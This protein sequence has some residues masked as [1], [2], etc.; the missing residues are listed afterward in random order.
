[1]NL[2]R[3][4][5]VTTAMAAVMAGHT[6]VLAQVSKP[7]KAKSKSAFSFQNVVDKAQALSLKPYVAPATAL[8]AG[9]SDLSYDAYRR[10]QFLHPKA[11]WATDDLGFRLEM[12]HRGNLFKERIDLYEVRDGKALPIDYVP[13]Q[14]LYDPPL[15]TPLPADTGFAG[16]RLIAQNGI[17]LDEIAAFLG[18][19]YFRSLGRGTQ[20]GLSARGLAIATGNPGGEEFPIFRAY[21]IERP[22][23]GDTAIRVHALLDSVS[24]AGAYSFKITPGDTTLF[25][26]EATL[27]PRVALPEIGIAPLTSMFLFGP[28]TP[29]RF[30]DYRPAVQDSNGFEMLTGTDEAIWRPLINPARLTE[31]AFSDTSPHGFG[32]I[33]RATSFNDYQDLEARY[34]RRPSA[35]ITPIG[36]WNEG[37]VHLFEFP[38]QTEDF[39]NIVAMWRPNTSLAPHQSHTY[40]YNIAWGPHKAPQP[41]LGRVLQTRTGRAQ[42]G[43]Q[44]L[45][46]VDFAVPSGGIA[47]LKAALTTSAGTPGPVQLH[48][49]SAPDTVRATFYYTPDSDKNA[50]FR[51]VLMKDATPVTETWIYRWT[52]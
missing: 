34:E 24:I 32:L 37:A 31:S 4:E 22:A 36:D 52:S 48:A 42:S 30:D 7:Q 11:L 40:R 27:F 23:K 16:F 28:N 3:R 8:P 51:L 9:L 39:D 17:D 1:M 18:A 21:W 43:S 15:A 33:Q 47:Q 38:T 50:D 12:F 20:Y 19:S 14:F 44:K 25:E 46:V 49:L 45:V 29:G 35:W 10:I 13:D 41:A 6:S 26:V 2:R 5:F